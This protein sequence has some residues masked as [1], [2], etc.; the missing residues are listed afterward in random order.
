MFTVASLQL[1]INDQQTK[2]NR[3]DYA[4]AQMDLARGADL[5]LLPE[6]WNTGYFN[7]NLYKRESEPLDGL[8]ITAIAEKAREIN[9]YVF[10]GSFVENAAGNLY[11]TSVLLDNNGKNIG[12]YRKIHLFSYGSREKE[13]L[14]PGEKAVVINTDLGALGLSTCYDLRF[15]EL[16]RYMLDLGA[17]V[18]LVTAAWPFPRWANWLTLN[19]A[20]ALE[21]ICYLVSCNCAGLNQGVSFLGHSSV[22]DPRGIIKAGSNEEPGIISSTI[23]LKRVHQIRKSLSQ[24]N[25]RTLKFME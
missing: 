3:I 2:Q 23:D 9:A 8:T 17:E 5:I 14:T 22:V 7:F 11:N 13:V 10:A 15:P 19:Q 6:I 20:R 16:Y 18:F 4:L 25:D 12:T 21:N 24:L 1:E